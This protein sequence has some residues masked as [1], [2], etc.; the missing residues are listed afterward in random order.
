MERDGSANVRWLYDATVGRSFTA[1]Y[2]CMMR[3]IDE[4]GLRD[5]RREVLG[6]A[7]GRVLD[8]GTGTGSNLRLFPT[9]VEELVLAEPDAHM[10]SVLRR[11]VSEMDGRAIELVQAPAESLPFE[12]SSFDCVT[13]TMVIC[14]MPDPKCGL[15]EIAR[16]LKPGGS[17][18]F[19][20]HVRSGNPRIARTQ[21]RLE[22]SW[23][24]IADGCHCNRDSLAM[25]EASRL[26]VQ[27][28]NLGYMPLAP[29]FIKPLIFGSAILVP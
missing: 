1:W 29:Q 23:R 4:R 2:G 13:A 24:F 5:T 21:D 9:A 7:H 27:R 3:L 14:T 10:Q 22:R 11:R 15:D 17:F 12:D 20:E 26:T 19:L 25:I 8:I 28:V 18:L 16:V 6:E